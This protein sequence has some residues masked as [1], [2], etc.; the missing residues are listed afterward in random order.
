MNEAEFCD[1]VV[2]LKDGEKIADDNVAALYKKHPDAHSFED[3]FLEYF[4][5]GI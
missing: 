1:R 4:S 5:K 2:L 3:I